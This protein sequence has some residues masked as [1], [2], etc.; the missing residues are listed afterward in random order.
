[1]KK[2]QLAANAEKQLAGSGWLL[3]LLWGKE[4]V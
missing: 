4:A 1:M 2:H 3:A